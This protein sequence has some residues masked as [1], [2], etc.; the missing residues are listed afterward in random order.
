MFVH[1]R[2]N[3]E[4][5]FNFLC[6]VIVQ[7]NVVNYFVFVNLKMGQV[8]FQERVLGLAIYLTFFANKIIF[9]RCIST[10]NMYYFFT[11]VTLNIS[12][13]LNIALKRIG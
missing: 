13:N 9:L 1:Y 12:Y 6:R 2:K 10:A 3:M 8:V 5:N 7:E 4:T 11:F